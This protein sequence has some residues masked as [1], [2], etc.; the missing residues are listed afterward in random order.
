MGIYLYKS[1]Q[2]VCMRSDISRSL[3]PRIVA[4]SYNLHSISITDAIRD[5]LG[6]NTTEITGEYTTNSM[7]LAFANTQDWTGRSPA[8]ILDERFINQDKEYW[9]NRGNKAFACK[10]GNR[11]DCVAATAYLV[12]Q[13]LNPP[14]YDARIEI[15][16]IENH[17]IVVVN[18]RGVIDLFEHWGDNCFIIDIWYNNHFPKYRAHAVFWADD[19]LHPIHTAIRLNIHNIRLLVTINE[20]GPNNTIIPLIPPVA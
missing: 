9:L 17:P 18:R 3:F 4:L 15:L 5:D 2:G 14:S 11:M 16:T 12:L 1:T 10:S 7:E 13:Y 8:R 20:G 19:I 6:G